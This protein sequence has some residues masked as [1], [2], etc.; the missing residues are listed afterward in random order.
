[1]TSQL[2][3]KGTT[4]GSV[5]S[6]RNLNTKTTFHPPSKKRGGKWALDRTSSYGSSSEINVV[7]GRCDFVNRQPDSVCL[8]IKQTS[9]PL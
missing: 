7:W 6:S 4:V 5:F 9:W 2:S 3:Q 1:M 8:R